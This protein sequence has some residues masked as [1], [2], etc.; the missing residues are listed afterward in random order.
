[1]MKHE[2]QLPIKDELSAIISALMGGAKYGIKIRLPHAFVM[3]FLFRNDLNNQQKMRTIVRLVLEHAS[4]L[5]AFA[6]IYKSILAIFKWSS[7]YL[8]QHHHHHLHPDRDRNVGR[9]LLRLIVDGPWFMGDTTSQTH[10]KTIPISSS[11]A[12]H[13]ERPY[14]SLVAG[15]CGGFIVWGRYSKINE[16]II[17]YLTSRVL[18]GLIQR[19]WELVQNRHINPSQHQPLHEQRLHQSILHHPR[20]FSLLAATVW[21]I[22]MVLFEDSPHVLHRSLKA[23]MDEI[24]RF[25]TI[26][27][28]TTLKGKKM[29]VTPFFLP[30]QNHNNN[31]GAGTF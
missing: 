2:H 12:G 14:H 20:T 13:P 15:A 11:L 5:A 1:M 6:T 24:Y 28:T 19:L 26:G 29:S 18:V 30:D 16:Q 27:W 31:N 3:T 25:P 9:L 10:K 21:G 7:R 4:H 8:R 17:L 23:S 22:V